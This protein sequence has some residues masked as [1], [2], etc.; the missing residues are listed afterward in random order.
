MTNLVIFDI[1]RSKSGKTLRMRLLRLFA[2]E[3]VN[4]LQDSVWDITKKEHLLHR[5]IKD[6]N[7]LK[8][9]IKKE[10]GSEPRIFMIRGKMKDLNKVRKG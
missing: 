6:V 4:K 1:P 3:N 2:K 7:E 9:K 5:I 10:M 8:N